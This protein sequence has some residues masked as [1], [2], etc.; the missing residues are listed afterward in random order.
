MVLSTTLTSLYPIHRKETFFSLTPGVCFAS[1]KLW[2]STEMR[3]KQSH[4][5]HSTTNPSREPAIIYAV[6]SMSEQRFRLIVLWGSSES[7]LHVPSFILSWMFTFEFLCLVLPKLAGC[8][9][10]SHRLTLASSKSASQNANSVNKYK[11]P[12]TAF[13]ALFRNFFYKMENQIKN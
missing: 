6:L 4:T 1:W 2:G 13:Y 5:Q 9:S 7:F 3:E 8:E 10:K 11:F 12:K